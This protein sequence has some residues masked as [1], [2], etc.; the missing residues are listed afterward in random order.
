MQ[1]KLLSGGAAQ[2]LVGAVAAQF[3]AETGF[4]IDGEFGAVG[5]MK[6]R[7]LD[8]DP[9]DLLILTRALIDELAA[10]GHVEAASVPISAR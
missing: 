8:G 7:L 6:A 1:L 9:A 10:G 4:D 2:A 3:K 5:A